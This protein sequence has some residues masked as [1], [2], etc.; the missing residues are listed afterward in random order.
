MT[1]KTTKE[2]PR[3]A[4]SYFDLTYKQ[5]IEIINRAVKAANKE[6]M[7]VMKPSPQPVWDLRFERVFS[8]SP[9]WEEYPQ[10]KS[11][12]V[13]PIKRFI[14]NLLASQTSTLKEKIEERKREE[15]LLGKQTKNRTYTI[16]YN[17]A[18]EDILNSL[19]EGK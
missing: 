8:T 3:H 12:I 13:Y 4:K 2:A 7:K 14:R 1:L 11:S 17:D 10:N 9:I 19:E 5:R 18:L 15:D 16:A 6:Q